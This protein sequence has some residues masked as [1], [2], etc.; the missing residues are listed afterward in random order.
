MNRYATRANRGLF[1]YISSYG[2]AGGEKAWDRRFSVD[3]P[4]WTLEHERQLFQ[5]RPTGWKE[6]PAVGVAERD[7]DLEDA[8][9]VG[10]LMVVSE[11]LK[12]FFEALDPVAAEYIPS[13][14]E[15]KGK[16]VAERYYLMHCVQHIDC[17]DTYR[18][19]EF[20]AHFRKDQ[21]MEWY[22]A[23][24]LPHKVPANV[25]IFGVIG[26]GRHIMARHAVRVAARKHKFTGIHFEDYESAMGSNPSPD[27][28]TS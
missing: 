24:I 28:A 10:T 18:S 11:R 22:Y 6:M 27:S 23:A 13:R 14:V 21:P 16:Q 17:I 3:F 7:H 9:N 2:A 12:A 19:R 5:G 25:S 4:D 26:D 20:Q 15:F 8:P 1:W